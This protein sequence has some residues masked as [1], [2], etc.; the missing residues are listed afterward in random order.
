MTQTGDRFSDQQLRDAIQAVEWYAT[1]ELRPGI[2][3]PGWFD[4]RSLAPKLP[5]PDLHGARC[6]DVG[7][8]EGFWAMEMESRGAS[9]VLGIDILNPRDWDWPTGSLDETV[10]GLERRKRGGDGFVLVTSEL[11]SGI[12][13]REMSVYDLDPTKVGVFDFVYMGSLLLH[14]R[15]PVRALERCV[16][17]LRP[18]GVLMS[19]DAIDLELT[20]LHPR[21]PVASFEGVGRPWWWK[22]NALGQRRLLESAGLVVQDDPRRIYMPIGEGQ[23]L[24]RLQLKDVLSPVGRELAITHRRGDPHSVVLGRRPD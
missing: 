5:W 18:G 10:E 20:F 6:L 1:I 13:R 15:D 16:K 24:R 3:T 19:V 21:R 4:L 9:E 8:F 12:S 22:A 14:L 23:S 11:Q 2:V 17:I 7:T